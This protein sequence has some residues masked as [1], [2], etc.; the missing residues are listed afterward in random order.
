MEIMYNMQ[1]IN[2]RTGL[3]NRYVR[4]KISR[5]K[6]KNNKGYSKDKTGYFGNAHKINVKLSPTVES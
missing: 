4:I 2:T 3:L 6:H 5:K 1:R